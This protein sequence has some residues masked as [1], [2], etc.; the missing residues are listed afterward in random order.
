MYVP[1]DW[2]SE[3]S[4]KA[5]KI[6]ESL[7]RAVYM[8]GFKEEEVSISTFTVSA[9]YYLAMKNSGVFT[10]R[11]IGKFLKKKGVLHSVEA[12]MAPHEYYPW[13]DKIAEG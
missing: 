6:L 11:E 4:P 1:K 5:I 10:V 13:T 2:G 9:E 3:L 7:A 12:W 8:P